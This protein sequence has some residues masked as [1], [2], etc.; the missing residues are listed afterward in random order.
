MLNDSP[1]LRSP[2]SL[3]NSNSNLSTM[4]NNQSTNNPPIASSYPIP[5]MQYVNLYSDENMLKAKSLEPPR[6]ITEG[7]LVIYYFFF[8][9]RSN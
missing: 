3:S 4:N 6:Q 2:A 1:N 8:K 5:P 9:K 7:K